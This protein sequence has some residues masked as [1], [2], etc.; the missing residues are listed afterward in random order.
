MATNAMR[1]YNLF[2]CR[3]KWKCVRTATTV[4]FIAVRAKSHEL[5]LLHLE[6]L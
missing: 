4:L 5:A 6:L 2:T 3:S 1:R